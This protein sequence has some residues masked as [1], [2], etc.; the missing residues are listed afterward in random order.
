MTIN[1]AA[2]HDNQIQ[3][4]RIVETISGGKA[5]EALF[6][7]L[8]KKAA[9][10]KS[11]RQQLLSEQRQLKSAL[12]PLHSGIDASAFRR[13][14]IDFSDIVAEAQPDEMQ[15]LMRLMVKQIEWMP[16]ESQADD[17]PGAHRVQFYAWPEQNQGLN[18]TKSDPSKIEKTYSDATQNRFATNV[19]YG[20]GTRTRT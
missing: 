11:E 1:Q 7:M 20:W 6:E 19:Q 3:I 12:S 14:L 9:A 13:Q 8:N 15:R 4:D 16:K 2:L 17:L 10:L 5:T 18:G